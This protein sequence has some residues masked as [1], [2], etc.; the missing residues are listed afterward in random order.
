MLNGLSQINIELTSRCDKSCS[1]CGHQDPKVNKNLKFGDIDYELLASV[2][3]SLPENI[4]VQ[5]HRDGEPL[6]YPELKEALW[7]FTDQIRSIVTN[8]NKLAEKADEI[9]DNC[10]TVT[11]SVFRAD[12]QEDQQLESLKKFLKIKGDRRPNVLIKIVG[13]IETSRQAVFETMG[14]QVIYRLLH[15]PQ[16]SFGYR[17]GRPTIPETGIC[18]DFLTHPSVDWEGRVFVC[19]RLDTEQSGYM[20]DLNIDSLDEIWNGER[21]MKWLD[22]HRRGR[23][24]LASPLCRNCEFW[25]IASG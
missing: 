5:F 21:R 24:D 6:I 16:G 15:V 17:K 23:R 9:I 19:N 25:G 10:D 3:Q 1:F 7:L 14:L 20:G 13:N 8:G 11:V 2:S 18:Q 12:E 4:V 22:A